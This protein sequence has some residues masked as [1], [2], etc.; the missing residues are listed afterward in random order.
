VKK[1]RLTLDTN[2]LVS[3]FVFPGRPIQEIVER[4]IAGH[5]QL[6]ISR[7]IMDELTD[8]LRRKFGWDAGKNADLTQ[9]LLRNSTLVMPD[10]DIHVIPDESDNRILECACA[11]KADYIISGD[12]HITRLKKYRNIRILTPSEYIREH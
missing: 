11:F 3:A 7:P 2:V 9:F 5:C 6:G 10:I 4:V 8:V 12:K 1:E